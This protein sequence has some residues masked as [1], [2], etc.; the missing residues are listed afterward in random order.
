MKGNNFLSGL[1]LGGVLGVVA[2][3]IT[4]STMNKNQNNKEQGLNLN[5]IKKN[6][7]KT[8][9]EDEE[10]VQFQNIKENSVEKEKM[11][12][13]QED[14]NEIGEI[15]GEKV[16]LSKKIAQLEGILKKMREENEGEN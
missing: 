2:A 4:V 8:D 12:S 9:E 6:L 15:I 7:Q 11:N 10:N 1:M 13:S 16:D 5:N 14:E 3:L